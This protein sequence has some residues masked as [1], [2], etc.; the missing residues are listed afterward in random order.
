MFETKE[1]VLDYLFED[2]PNKVRPANL[3]RHTNDTA[4]YGDCFKSMVFPIT[5]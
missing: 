5:A 4:T 1:P 2:A 3:K